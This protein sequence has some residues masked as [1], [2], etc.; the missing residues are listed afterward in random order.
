MIHYLFQGQIW[1]QTLYYYQDQSCLIFASE[2]KALLESP[3]VKTG[4]DKEILR[5]YLSA[6]QRMGTVDS[7]QK[8]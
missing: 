7:F 8:Y 6:G 5:D 3:Y 4:P 2:V 1:Y